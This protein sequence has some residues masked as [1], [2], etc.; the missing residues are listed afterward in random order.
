ME[1]SHSAAVQRRTKE[2]GWRKSPAVLVDQPRYLP[3]STTTAA[4]TTTAAAVESAAT[5][6]AVEATTTA[7]AAA[8]ME[9]AAGVTAVEAAGSADITTVETAGPTY[10]CV[11]R[12]LRNQQNRG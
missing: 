11:R 5:A 7:Q 4:V 10:K 8:A 12:H 2:N 9:S 6:T 1:C 3:V